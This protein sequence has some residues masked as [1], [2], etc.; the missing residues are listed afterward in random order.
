MN[1]MLSLI[2]PTYNRPHFLKR[3]LRYFQQQEFPYRIVV[4]DSSSAPACDANLSIVA[5]LR[6]NL[7]IRYEK[8]PFEIHL[9]LK[10]AQALSGVDSKY[11]VI[12]ADDDFLVPKAIELCVRF[13]EANSDYSIAH[14]RAVRLKYKSIETRG[15]HNDLRINAYPQCDIGH[16]DPGVRLQKHLANYSATFY[17]VHRRSDLMRNMQLSY[18]NS[19]DCRF[20]EVLPSCLSIIQGK[21]KRLDI[22]YMVRQS[23]R[24]STKMA[25]ARPSWPLLFTSDD[26][27]KSYVQFRDCLAEELMSTNDLSMMETKDIVNHAFLS[28]MAQM[29]YI[30]NIGQFTWRPRDVFNQAAQHIRQGIKILPAAARFAVFGRQFVDVLRSPHEV[31]RKLRCEQKLPLI[32]PGSRFRTD[33]MPIYKHV[34][35]YPN[36]C[37]TYDRK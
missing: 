29:L 35:H 11:A 23:V 26:F 28:F 34:M 5:S 37:N 2:I 3:L 27:S 19:I 21:A 1:G 22:L 8:Y 33:F 7:S 13:L 16:N 36:G 6:N 12:C 25:I 17:S 4:A 10:I 20:G 9:A 15:D 30:N 32:K 31:F 18:D 14:G 24:D